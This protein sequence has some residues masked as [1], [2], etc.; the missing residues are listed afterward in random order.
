MKTEGVVG[1]HEKQLTLPRS[2]VAEE[3]PGRMEPQLQA[4]WISTLPPPQQGTTKSKTSDL[5]D[6]DNKGVP[7]LKV[8]SMWN[9]LDNVGNIW[10]PLKRGT[11]LIGSMEIQI[12]GTV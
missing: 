5:Q 7:F 12:T 11:G 9:L 6:Q 10:L 8:L 2:P 3:G 1:E 4:T